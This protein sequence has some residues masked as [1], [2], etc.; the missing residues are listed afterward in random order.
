VF[1]SE[2]HS[3]RTFRNIVLWFSIQPFGLLRGE[4]T[5]VITEFATLYLN[6]S[7]A[8]YDQFR[9]MF[10]EQEVSLRKLGGAKYFTCGRDSMPFDPKA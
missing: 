8:P 6:C 9:E 7:P 2:W 1:C 3:F 10:D 5:L 4:V